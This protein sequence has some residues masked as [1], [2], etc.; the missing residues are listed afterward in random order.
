MYSLSGQIRTGFHRHITD[1]QGLK[2]AVVSDDYSVRTKIDFVLVEYIEAV[3]IRNYRRYR[4]I[5]HTIAFVYSLATY[6]IA[7]FETRHGAR[8]RLFSVPECIK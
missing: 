1:I 3:L 6:A 5:P 4:S 7:G 2:L 8:M